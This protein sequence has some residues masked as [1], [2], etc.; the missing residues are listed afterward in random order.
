MGH[1][2]RIDC[3][4]PRGQA[5]ADSARIGPDPGHQAHL[6]KSQAEAGGQQA[7]TAKTQAEAR[8]PQAR[9]AKTQAEAPAEARARTAYR[10][11]WGLGHPALAVLLA[12]ALTLGC[13]NVTGPILKAMRKPGEQ[14]TTFPDVVWAEYDCDKKKRP[15]FAVERNELMPRQIKPGGDFNHRMVYVMCPKRSTEVVKGLLRTRVR[16]KGRPIVRQADEGYEI[17]PG[18]WTIDSLI[19]LPEAAEPG[20]YAYEVQFKSPKL[21]FAKSLTFVV[22]AP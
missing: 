16:F 7:R 18:R 3:Q 11:R 9:T 21:R 19:Q 10:G 2:T 5:R 8:G 20:V 22:R 15:F 4:S 6:A 12:L 17:K 1:R 14:L 13:V